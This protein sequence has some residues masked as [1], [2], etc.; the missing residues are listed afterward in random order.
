MAKYSSGSG[1]KKASICENS[2]TANSL[3]Y[4]ILKRGDG[5]V[6]REVLETLIQGISDLFIEGDCAAK[7][8]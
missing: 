3:P 2:P 7:P 5:D 4:K 1:T 6:S 8:E